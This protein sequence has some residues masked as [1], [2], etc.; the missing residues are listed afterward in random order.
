[1][2]V[3]SPVT[4]PDLDLSLV[5]SDEQHLL[6]R[7]QLAVVFELLPAIVLLRGWTDDFD[8]HLGI[9][10]RVALWILRIKLEVVTDDGHVKAQRGGVI[11]EPWQA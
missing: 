9:E 1:M 11:I 5:V 8:D 3:P 7:I 10:H 6:K 2:T 4:S